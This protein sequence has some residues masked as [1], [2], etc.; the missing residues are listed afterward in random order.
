MTQQDSNRVVERVKGQLGSL[1]FENIALSDNLERV[2]IELNEKTIL[3]RNQEITIK[4][5]SAESQKM[6]QVI[7]DKYKEIEDLKDILDE[8]DQII[9]DLKGELFTLKSKKP[10]SAKNKS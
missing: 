4:E 3:L 8:K 10:I 5:G 2:N 1:M 6:E 7:K 9:A